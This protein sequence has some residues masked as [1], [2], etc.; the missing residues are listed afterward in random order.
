M[1]GV[2]RAPAYS[3]PLPIA[4]PDIADTQPSDQSEGKNNY[5]LAKGKA[6]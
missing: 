1:N 5:A 2:R 4:A 3:I 6:A